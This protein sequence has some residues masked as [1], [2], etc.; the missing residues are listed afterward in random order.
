MRKDMAGMSRE[1]AI[2][3]TIPVF[4]EQILERSGK[5]YG[6][7]DILRIPEIQTKALQWKKDVL[8][9]PWNLMRKRLIAGWDNEFL[10][11]LILHDL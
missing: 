10:W 8:Y 7:L 9:L 6:L 5:I 1:S 3:A 2:A 11:E 4:W